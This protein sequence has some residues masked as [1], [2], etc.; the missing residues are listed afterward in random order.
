MALQSFFSLNVVPLSI[1]I[2]SLPLAF[3]LS[4]Y[5]VP[6]FSNYALLRDIP[7]PLAARFSSLWLMLQARRGRRFL[8]VDAAHEKY[9]TFVRI[10][11]DHVSV[12]D[13][14]AI[15]LIY[16]HGNGFLKRLVV[17]FPTSTTCR[18]HNQCRHCVCTICLICQSCASRLCN[19]TPF[20][21]NKLFDTL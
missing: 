9:G 8:S 17:I 5:L 14:A 16:G 4:L 7:G 3:F 6:Y 19:Y 11:P 21:S 2:I 15:P 10:Q 18:Q 13:E 12:A 1:W 20:T